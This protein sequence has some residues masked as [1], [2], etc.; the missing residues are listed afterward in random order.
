MKVCNVKIEGPYLLMHNRQLADPLND[1]VRAKA[2]FTAKKQ[3]TDDDH[4]KISE[5]EFF[6]G[7]YID[8][9]EQPIIPDKSIKAMLGDAAKSFREGPKCKEGVLIMNNSVLDFDGPK[10]IHQ[11]WKKKYYRREP[12]KQK[13]SVIIRTRPSFNNWKAELE[14][15]YDEKIVNPDMLE[16]WLDIASKYKGIGDGRPT[17]G[18]F[19]I[20]EI[21]HKE[22]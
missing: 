10:S 22:I 3:K 21:T 16:R 4:Q 14:I 1:F 13:T 17:F 7:L 18:R 19:N 2:E 12:L 11:R 8:E 9:K 6:A 5:I 15:F 20:A